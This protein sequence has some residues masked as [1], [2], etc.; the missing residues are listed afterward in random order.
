MRAAQAKRATI[1]GVQDGL[2]ATRDVVRSHP[3]AAMTVALLAGAA[4]ALIVMPA[5]RRHGRVARLAEWLPSSRSEVA[6]I[7]NN[8]NSRVAKSSA[9][10]SL[11]SAFERVVDSVTSIDANSS[12]TPAIKRA[13]TWLNSLRAS[14]NGK[15]S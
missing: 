7:A 14:I 2:D 11:A 3:A 4:V 10:S 1:A 8:L 15:T 9:M 13:G 6:T 5:S 12:L